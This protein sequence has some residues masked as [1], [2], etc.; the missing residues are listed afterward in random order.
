MLGNPD[1]KPHFFSDKALEPTIKA[2][3]KKFPLMDTKSSSVSLIHY[4]TA[5]STCTYV[6]IHTPWV[7]KGRH[8]TLVHI[9][10]KGVH[11]GHTQKHTERPSLRASCYEEERRHSRT[12]SV[13]SSDVLQVVD[14]FGRCV[15]AGMHSLNIRWAGVKINQLLLPWGASES[16]VTVVTCHMAGVWR[17]IR[18][19]T[20]QCTGAQG[21]RDNQAAATGDARIHLTWSVASE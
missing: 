9:L 15:N 17:L 6:H 2:I 12:P 16:T 13:H 3:V 5:T 11:C 18:V 10:W 19:P 7:K 20:G 1:S 14:G 21:T 4:C 8:Y